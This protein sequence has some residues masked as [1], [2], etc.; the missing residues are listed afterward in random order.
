MTLKTKAESKT[1]TD[2]PLDVQYPLS[3][4]DGSQVL[5]VEV[6]YS[7]LCGAHGRGRETG[8]ALTN[9]VVGDHPERVVHPG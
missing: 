4:P 5:W 3:V 7:I 2:R 9:L 1:T 6:R 8:V